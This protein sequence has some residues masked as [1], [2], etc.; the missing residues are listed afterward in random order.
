MTHKIDTDD[1]LSFAPLIGFRRVSSTIIILTAY[2]RLLWHVA[3]ILLLRWGRLQ[4]IARRPSDGLL[5]VHVLRCVGRQVAVRVLRVDWRRRHGRSGTAG[6]V[7]LLLTLPL[8][9]ILI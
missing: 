4:R 2:H 3:S 8:V 1:E 9:D 6:H 5:T 7:L